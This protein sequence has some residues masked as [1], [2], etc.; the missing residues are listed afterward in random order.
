MQT[1]IRSAAEG[2]VKKNFELIYMCVCVRACIYILL[3]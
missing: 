2:T 3:S 1:S